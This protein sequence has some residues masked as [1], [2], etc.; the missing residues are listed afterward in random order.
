MDESCRETLQ[1]T[2]IVVG[3]SDGGAEDGKGSFGWTIQS[4][5]MMELI[6][7]SGEVEGYVPTSFRCEDTGM[8]SVLCCWYSMLQHNWISQDHLLKLYC[9]NEST[10][11]YARKIL[12]KRTYSLPQDAPELD[13]LYCIKSLAPFIRETVL[14]DWVKGHQKDDIL[15]LEV[16]LNIRADALATAALKT[17]RREVVVSPKSP[18]ACDLIINTRSVMGRKG[19]SI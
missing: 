17:A 8:L 16:C 5:D 14:V 18:A 12:S 7:C 6:F 15:P 11:R 1:R 9:D 3:C 10:V 19:R 13:L 2:K 4:E